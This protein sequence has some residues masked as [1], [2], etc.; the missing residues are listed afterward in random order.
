MKEKMR[1]FTESEL[2]RLTRL[3]LLAL[4]RQTAN[5]LANAP[6]LSPDREN[7]CINL[8]RISRALARRDPAP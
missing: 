4:L 8:R 5:A 1:V 2:L 3:E 7:A 6:E